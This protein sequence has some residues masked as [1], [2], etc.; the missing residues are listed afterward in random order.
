M[1]FHIFGLT[2]CI[3]MSI[4]M[5]Y[6]SLSSSPSWTSSIARGQ[7]WLL[8]IVVIVIISLFWLFASVF[9]YWM[10]FIWSWTSQCRHGDQRL[11]RGVAFHISPMNLVRLPAPPGISLRLASSMFARWGGTYRATKNQNLSTWLT[12]SALIWET[13]ILLNNISGTKKNFQKPSDRL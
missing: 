9:R 13:Y 5:L 2:R 11:R 10:S 6:R 12:A 4:P 1:V 7:R 3:G 8:I